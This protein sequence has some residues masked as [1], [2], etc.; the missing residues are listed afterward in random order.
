MS[1]CICSLNI[2]HLN[3][4][5]PRV[6][7]F[8][9]IIKT[10]IPSKT[11]LIRLYKRSKML[12]IESR[13]YFGSKLVQYIPSFIN[14]QFSD[15]LLNL[16]HIFNKTYERLISIMC[17]DYYLKCLTTKSTDLHENFHVNI[18]GSRWRYDGGVSESSEQVKLNIILC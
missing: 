9:P 6:F 5:V 13:N 1:L 11:E 12:Y 4:D 16:I 18:C 7:C 3:K 2:Y 17:S 14:P 8:T 10:N 15:V